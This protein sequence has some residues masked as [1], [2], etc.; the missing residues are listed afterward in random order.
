M[1]FIKKW[2]RQF[3]S[4]LKKIRTP[5]WRAK[6][7]YIK[8][9]DTL[10]LDDKTILLESEHG[11]KL[12][13]NIFYV[14]RHLAT[15]PEYADYKIYFASWQ[16]FIPKFRTF[17]ENHGMDRI[18]L[19]TFSSEEYFRL[20]ASA[21]YLINDTTFGPYFM[22]KEGQVY[23]NTWHGTPLKTLG[24]KDNGGYHALG[25][26]QKNFVCSDY[27]LF[28]NEH[29]RDC[30]IED[31]MLENIS[32]GKSVLSGYPRNEI[33][34][35]ADSRRTIRETLGLGDAKV[36]AYMPTYR[37]DFANK[38]ENRS[39]VYL[40]Y[41]LFE[42]DKAMEE[43]EIF[44]V[45]LH[46]LAQ[47]SVNFSEF[48]HL[49][50]FPKEYETYEFLNVAD[51]LI[52]DYSSVFFDFALTRQKIVLFTYDKDEYLADRGLYMPMES[53]PFPQVA[54]VP[55][56]LAELRSGKQY[57]ET[58]FLQK[59]CSYDSI[60]ASA[61]LLDF[62]LLGKNTGL[63]AE[64]IPANGKEN[65]LIYAGNLA[66]NGI[67]TSLRS[68]LNTIDLSKRN[69]YISFMTG[70]M[71]NNRENL[72]TFPSDVQ[73][74]PLTGDMN[75]TLTERILRKLFKEKI[76][77][78][79]WY[80]KW[81]GKRVHQDL[82]R[83]VGT[84]RFDRLIQFNGYEQEVILRYSSFDGPNIIFVHNDMTEEIRS[85]GNQRGDVLRYAYSHYDKVAVVTEDIMPPTK[86]I[87][88]CHDNLQVVRNT[89]PYNTILARSEEELRLD[90]FTISSGK[91]DRSHVVL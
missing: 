88:H 24:K 15:S 26:V 65:V 5:H 73:Y 42:L 28:P 6:S 76:L 71:K 78:A 8:Y 85:R 72:L 90:P 34:F 62:V 58:A 82:S 56:L 69:Y 83:T 44:Y 57:D 66:A 27:L 38:K 9:F 22:K 29:T 17:F 19:V 35:D 53:L 50:P 55:S 12:D 18:Q 81:V 16:R 68:L 14:A 4:A 41:Y 10:S 37:G 63:T 59:Y 43:G 79:K 7:N 47:K 11:K 36:Y 46:P 31:Y 3:K 40:F 86:K 13:G 25:N 1:N 48:K 2:I 49:R 54:D 39:F 51:V 45:N 84:A 23:L 21:K 80:M 30:L 64:P 61:R 87:S 52:T 32:I 20:L 67:T 74:F 75:L 33:F 77:S 91:S 89:I 60:D 70:K